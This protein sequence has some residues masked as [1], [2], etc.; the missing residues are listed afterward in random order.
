MIDSPTGTLIVTN[1]TQAARGYDFET[2]KEIWSISNNSE[3]AVP[4]PFVAHNLIYVS[5]GYRPV[6]PIYAI[7]LDAKGDL[8][9]ESDMN[10]SEY[11]AWS[12]TRGGPY[13][14]TP[15]VYGDYL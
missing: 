3:I 5:S 1:A 12:T 13:M 15:I 10:T 8:T 6:Q 9:L 11:L 7:R 14:P 4:T 2:G